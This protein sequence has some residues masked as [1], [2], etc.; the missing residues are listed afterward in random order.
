MMKKRIGLLLAMVMILSLVLTACG[1]GGGGTTSGGGQSSGGGGTADGGNVLIG[2]NYELSGAVASYGQDSVDGIKM[3]VDE[4]NAAGG[5]LGL[6]VSLQ[7]EDNKSDPAE[8]TSI[9]EKLL[10]KNGISASLGP[11]TSGNFRA[12]IPIAENYGVPVID[13]KSTRL[14]S[15]H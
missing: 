9:A 8:A 3:A 2:V 14:N 10:S 11:A 12:V 6:Q 13:R 15:S 1:G 7:I 4:V 5:V